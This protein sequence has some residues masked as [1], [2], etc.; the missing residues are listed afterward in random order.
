M[1]TGGGELCIDV[2]GSLTTSDDWSVCDDGG[3]APAAAAAAAAAAGAVVFEAGVAA[4]FAPAYRPLLGFF[5]MAS[6]PAALRSHPAHTQ[7][8]AQ[9]GHCH[10]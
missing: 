6:T 5:G 3:M 2:T 9:E 7:L 10:A 8:F 4:K 1:G